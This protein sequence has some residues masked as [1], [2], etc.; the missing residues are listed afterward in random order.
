M[1]AVFG[2]IQKIAS[3]FLRYSMGIILLWIG[4][5]KFADPSPVVGL[6]QASF[7][8]L[9]SN[10]IVYALGTVEIVAALALFAGFGT[11]YVGLLVVGLFAGTLAIFV[12][13]PKVTYGDKGFPFLALPGQFLLKDLVL[14]AASVAMVA[15][16]TARTTASRSTVPGDASWPRVSNTDPRPASPMTG[17]RR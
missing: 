7:P 14:M 17:A 4:A 1:D 5:L 16:E 13:A 3:P 9:A 2:L 11:R 6:L 8:F 10:G 12:V 15:M